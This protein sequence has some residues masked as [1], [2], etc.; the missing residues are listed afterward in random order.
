[1]RPRD[2]KL[3]CLKKCFKKWLLT[4]RGR[5]GYETLGEISKK[6]E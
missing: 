5:L 6:I 3:I 2:V 1:M 4:P